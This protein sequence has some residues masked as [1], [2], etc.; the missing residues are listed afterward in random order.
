MRIKVAAA[1]ASPAIM[2][3]LF[4]ISVAAPKPF[5]PPN[6]WNAVQQQAPPGSTIQIWTHDSGPLQQTV[7]VL[8]DPNT[9]YADAVQVVQKNI[10]ANKFKVTA[11]KDQT[12]N[13]QTG[14]FFEMSYGPDVGRVAVDRL[15]IPDGP[16]TLTITYMRPAPEPVADEVKTGLNT[17]CG[18][19]VL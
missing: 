8:D 12:C 9:A 5:P 15:I 13:G 3:A 4:G 19:T 11:N 17:Y 16:G 2:L 6:G 7:T 10:A 14:H 1:F 18:T